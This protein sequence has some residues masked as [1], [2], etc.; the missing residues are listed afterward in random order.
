MYQWSRVSCFVVV[1]VVRSW[2]ISLFK[3]ENRH[4]FRCFVNFVL[5][6]L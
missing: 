3:S 2:R 1:R 4:N 6:L 5:L